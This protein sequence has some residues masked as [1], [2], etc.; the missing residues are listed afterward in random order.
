[1]LNS[2][3]SVV[4]PVGM[5][6]M[7][8]QRKIALVVPTIR[9]ASIRRFL[10]E[11][12]AGGPSD[13]LGEVDLILVEDNPTHTMDLS[14]HFEE[15]GREN[16]RHFD[17]AVI[18]RELGDVSWIIPRRSDTVRSFGYW[19]AWKAGYEYIMTL[20]DDCYPD[21]DYPNPHRDHLRSLS[22]RTQWFSTLNTAR[23]RGLPYFNLGSRDDVKVNHGLWTNV[24]DYDAC[25]QLANPTPEQ[26]DHTSRIVPRR[27]YF[28]MC[29]MNV[30]WHRDATVAMYHLLMGQMWDTEFAVGELLKK[31]PFDRFGDIWCGIIMK[32]IADTV[33]WSVG[34]GTPYI[35]HDRASNPFA[36]LKKE[37][38]GVEVNELFWEWVDSIWMTDEMTPVECYK[39][40]AS[41]MDDFGFEKFSEHAS[42][43][44]D[45][46]RA[47]LAWAALFE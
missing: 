37:A 35:K 41:G 43:F 4:R 45:L 32:K 5:G 31:L 16:W 11:W 28:P 42:Y 14:D 20:D 3:G 1:M 8:N 18:D 7:V 38:N 23:P 30:M 24:V 10:S 22:K 40:I 33:G 46:R 27:S 21:K 17:W 44:D 36:N 6:K 29:G 2:G 34:T 15:D 19:Y 12:G 13:L 47:M 25:N 9:E 26:F 39:A